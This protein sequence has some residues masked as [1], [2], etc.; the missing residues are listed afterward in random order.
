MEKCRS[1][2]Y[3]LAESSSARVSAPAFIRAVFETARCD[4][5]FDMSGMREDHAQFISR[6]NA[7]R[8]SLMRILSYQETLEDDKRAAQSRWHYKRWHSLTYRQI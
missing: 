3:T 2:F 1:I 7:D 8:S 4:D 5:V 6:G